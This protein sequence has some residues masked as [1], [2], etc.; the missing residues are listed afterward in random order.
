MGPTMKAGGVPV[1]SLAH[2]IGIK[3]TW[4]LCRT[5]MYENKIPKGPTMKEDDVLPAPTRDNLVRTFQREHKFILSGERLLTEQ[6]IKQLYT[7]I[8]STP[9]NLSIYMLEGLRMQSA[10]SH[11]PRNLGLSRD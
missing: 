9:K 11:G 6:L 5:R 10:I 2:Q 1:E 8:H 7:E 4:M 3:K